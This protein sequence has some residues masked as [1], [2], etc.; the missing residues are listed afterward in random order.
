MKKFT[1]FFISTVLF[2]GLAFSVTAFA[3][4][5]AEL[6][7]MSTFISNF[8][9]IGMFNFDVRNMYNT[10]LEYFG[11]WH[12]WQNDSNRTRCKECPDE[13]C[14][15]GEYVV[16]KKY[17]SEAI[18]KYFADRGQ[19]FRHESFGDGY[20]HVHY[21]GEYYHFG[22]ITFDANAAEVFEAHKKGN[23]IIM[24]GKIYN[25]DHEYPEDGRSFT[26]RAKPYK[27]N[28]KNTWAILSL[29]RD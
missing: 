15:Y 7:K 22:G 4:T 14:P 17:V 3:S 5:P 16:H 6:K 27:Y 23:V 19:D 24:T 28:G 25:A 11:V 8:A 21:D 29:Q 1:N 13:D 26:A 18:K 12:V 10:E 9:E 20:G 2:L